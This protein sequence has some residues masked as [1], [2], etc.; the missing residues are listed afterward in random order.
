MGP[1]HG[2]GDKYRA[3]NGMAVLSAT[4]TPTTVAAV[5]RHMRVLRTVE[6]ATCSRLVLTRVLGRTCDACSFS[7]C[8]LEQITV[9]SKSFRVILKP[10]LAFLL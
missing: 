10:C 1:E 8:L 4:L 9:R 5:C 6:H 2:K 3:S 7:N